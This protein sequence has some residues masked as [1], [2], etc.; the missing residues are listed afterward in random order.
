MKINV[1]KIPDGGMNLRFEKDGAWFRGFLPETEPFG[2]T[3]RDINIACTV[4]RMRESVFIEGS[5]TAQAEAPCCRC[6]ETAQFPLATSFRYTF[7]PAPSEPQ[8]EVE[9]NTEDLELAYYEE[10]LIDL[11]RVLYEQIMLQ[12]PIKPLCR[13][14]CQ[15]LCPRCGINLNLANCACEAETFDERLSAL[16]QFKVKP[17]IQ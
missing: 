1:S 7:A 8:D 14:T 4:R 16:K 15:G 13:E 3:L 5:V 2:F 6:L 9:L 11:D 17:K 10:D 12:I